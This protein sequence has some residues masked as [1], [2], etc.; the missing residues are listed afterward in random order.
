M[1]GQ[2]WARGR[3]NENQEQTAETTRNTMYGRE[4]WQKEKNYLRE[5]YLEREKKEEDI[6]VPDTAQKVSH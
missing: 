1:K 4:E 2:R 6:I 3:M 5:L